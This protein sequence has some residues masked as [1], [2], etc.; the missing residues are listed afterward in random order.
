MLTNNVEF[1]TDK[2]HIIYMVNK[3]DIL[4]ESSHYQPNWHLKYKNKSYFLV[5]VAINLTEMFK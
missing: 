1:H 2:P 3:M 5:F 4:S